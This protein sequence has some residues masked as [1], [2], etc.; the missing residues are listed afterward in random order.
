MA[1]EQRPAGIHGGSPK[2]TGNRN[3][4]TGVSPPQWDSQWS[5]EKAQRTG[6]KFPIVNACWDRG[7]RSGMSTLGICKYQFT[8]R[9]CQQ[10][11][12]QQPRGYPLTL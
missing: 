4:N 8:L 5:A 9:K 11:R 12:L 1:Q 7:H 3:Q 10:R 2:Q 6:T